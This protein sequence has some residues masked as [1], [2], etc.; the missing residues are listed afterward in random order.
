LGGLAEANSHRQE[1]F[2]TKENT[3]MR[4]LVVLTFVSLDGVMQAPGGKGEDPSGG[5]DLEG[6]T[7]PYFDEAVGT[8]MEKQM[9]PPSD[10]L[11]GRK[12]YEIF[13]SY[14]P[15]HESDWP[16]VNSATKY[17]FSD[18]RT[19]S[20]WDN[21]VFI[22]N[23]VVEEIRR[24]KQQDGSDLQVH[25]S[26]NLIQTLLANDLVDELWLKIFPVTL[27]KGKRLFGEGTIPAAFKLTESK[28]APSGVIIASYKRDGAVKLGSF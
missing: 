2:M 5:F 7:V 1:N 23:N 21:T 24:L 15:A 16:G 14:W 10:L 11:L 20:L 17:V 4:K 9:T 18:T 12:T 26:S 25:G 27:G 3:T 6:W 22:K 8:A 13:A 19:D 28:M